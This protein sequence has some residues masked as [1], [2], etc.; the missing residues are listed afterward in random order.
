MS[1]IILSDPFAFKIFTS[2]TVPSVFIINEINIS[3]SFS[4]FETLNWY[5]P[6]PLN[7]I[8]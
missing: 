4:F 5:N 1:L 6:L 8:Y 3:G 2:D 7:T